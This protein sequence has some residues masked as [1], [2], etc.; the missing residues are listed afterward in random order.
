MTKA[1]K[2]QN[3]SAETYK[4]VNP[5]KPRSEKQ[6]AADAALGKRTKAAQKAKSREPIVA[7]GAAMAGMAVGG[8]TK[9]KPYGPPAN[10][11]VKAAAKK[12]QAKKKK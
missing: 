7:T 12:Q 8:G 5:P 11:S 6:R 2:V 1:E 4:T 9:V 10:K 3:K